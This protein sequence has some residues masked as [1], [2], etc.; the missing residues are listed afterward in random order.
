MLI[1]CCRYPPS[2]LID[3]FERELEEEKIF[4]PVGVTAI[5]IDIR[6]RAM[7][8]CYRGRLTLTDAAV[9]RLRCGELGEFL[10]SDMPLTSIRRIFHYK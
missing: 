4:R 10:P 5:S 9:P 6:A 7:D 1:P 8:P 3:G 2:I